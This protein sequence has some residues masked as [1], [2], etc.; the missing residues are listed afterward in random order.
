MEGMT[1]TLDEFLNA[2]KFPEG[3][4]FTPDLAKQIFWKVKGI[5]KEVERSQAY[6]KSTNENLEKAYVEL[7]L[8]EK[9]LADQNEKLSA[10]VESLGEGFL[11]FGMDGVCWDFHTRACLDL[12][13]ASRQESLLGRC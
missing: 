9:Q 2:P 8:K 4:S 12:L 10:L 6:W 3:E 11:I 7:D 5:Q 1:L 13:E